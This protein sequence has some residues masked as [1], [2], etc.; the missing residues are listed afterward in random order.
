MM[1]SRI[2][3]VGAGISGLA[4]A[5]NLQQILP[6]DSDIT[7]FERS[8]HV[9]GTAWTEHSE[10]YLLERG[11]N[12]FLDNRESTLRL[13]DSIGLT[14]RLVRANPSSNT[15]FIFLGDHLRALPASLMSFL[16]SDLLSWKGKLR[17]AWERFIRPK[18]DGGDESIYDFGCRRIGKEATEALLD[19]FVTGILAGESRQLSL[20]ASFPRMREMEMKYG[21]LFRAMNQL[22]KERKANA[23]KLDQ[24]QEPAPIGSPRGHLTT[25]AGGMGVLLTT[26]ASRLNRPPILNTAVD[27]IERASHQRWHVHHDQRVTEVD[28]VILSS[29]G[30]TQA[31]LLRPIDPELSREIEGIAYAPATVVVLGFPVAKF[32]KVPQGFGYLAPARLGRP[33]LGVIFSSSIFP[34]QSPEGYVQFRAILGGSKRP[35]VVDW[36]DDQIVA[37]VRDDLRITLRIEAEPSFRWIHRWPRAIPQYHLGHLDRLQRIEERRRQHPGLFLGGN[38]YRGVALNDCIVDAEKTAASVRDFIAH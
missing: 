3:V 36:S 22:A 1:P 16:T 35:D 27:R 38:L 21:G 2:A 5:W 34:H 12:G 10:G 32:T 11:P 13:C 23:K 31:Q 4:T 9:G 19:A 28:A 33:V 15:R 8:S 24:N 18:L 29:P 30:Q 26:L 37:A 25:I 17:V 20:P 6:P 7:V 14:D